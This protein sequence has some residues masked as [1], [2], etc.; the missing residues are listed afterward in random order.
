MARK[1]CVVV[2]GTWL[3]ASLS[4]GTLAFI[5]LSDMR[6]SGS[7]PSALLRHAASAGSVPEMNRRSCSNGVVYATPPH[8]MREEGNRNV[9]RFSTSSSATPEDLPTAVFAVSGAM[10]MLPMPAAAAEEVTAFKSSGAADA[11]GTLELGLL[12]LGLVV[13]LLYACN[14]TILRF[15][16]AAICFAMTTP[17]GRFANALVDTSDA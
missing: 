2:F 3:L 5:P 4:P 17:C 7:A 14:P 12:V 13:R 10:T 15:P 9:E 8:R 11:L 16:A 1:F 6:F